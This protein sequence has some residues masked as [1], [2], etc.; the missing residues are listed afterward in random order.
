MS[1]KNFGFWPPTLGELQRA[2]DCA[3][4]RRSGSSEAGIAKTIKNHSIKT[5]IRVGKSFVLRFQIGTSRSSSDGRNLRPF[6]LSI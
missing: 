4:L 5:V 1:I 3:R 6:R 2:K